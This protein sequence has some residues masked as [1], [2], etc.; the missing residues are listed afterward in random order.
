MI[1]DGQWDINLQPTGAM[2]RQHMYLAPGQNYD[3]KLHIDCALY[4]YFI[5]IR[6]ISGGQA[7]GIS[8]LGVHQSR[9]ILAWF[10]A[11]RNAL[12]SESY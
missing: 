11:M 10:L 12:P 9:P 8:P 2:V 1:T 4:F 3:L 5:I 7:D 6:L